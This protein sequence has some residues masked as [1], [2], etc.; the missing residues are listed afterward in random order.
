MKN[1]FFLTLSLLLLV[2]AGCG[3]KVTLRGKATFSDNGEPVPVGTVCFETDVFLARGDLKPDGTF[4]VGSL[5][6][7]DGLP[8]GKYRVYITGAEKIIDT[9]E[10]GINKYELLIDPKFADSKKSGIELEVTA[11]TKTFDV[12]VDRNPDAKN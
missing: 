3:D 7:S 10:K 4:I 1:V 11:S 8:P 5:K 6:A 12:V 9:D 2:L